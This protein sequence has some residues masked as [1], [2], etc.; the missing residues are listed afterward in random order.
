VKSPV[1]STGVGLLMYGAQQEIADRQHFRARDENIY[2]KVKKRM[3]AWLE[4]VF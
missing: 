3:T 2:T 4:D 1:Y